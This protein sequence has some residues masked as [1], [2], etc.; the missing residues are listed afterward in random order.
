M[1]LARRL[2]LSLIVLIGVLMAACASGPAAAT[3]APPSATPAVGGEPV[4]QAV[5]INLLKSN[6]LQVEVVIRGTLPDRCSRI[7][8]VQQHYE[9]TEFQITL[10]AARP[11]HSVCSAALIPF[12]EAVRLE[13]SDKPAGTYSVVANGTAASF[14]WPGSPTDRNDFGRDQARARPAG[15]AAQILQ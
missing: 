8:A 10:V 4:V 9:P 12:R 1:L 3:P 5:E 7:D 11:D 14:E 6:P 15:Q 13:M 2:G